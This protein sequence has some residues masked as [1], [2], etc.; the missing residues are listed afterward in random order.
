MKDSKYRSFHYAAPDGS[1]LRVVARSKPSQTGTY[2]TWRVSEF[3]KGKWVMPAF[4][5]ITY[6]ALAKLEYLGSTSK[7]DG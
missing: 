7:G 6:G 5:E 1:V 2:K 3:Q 4:P